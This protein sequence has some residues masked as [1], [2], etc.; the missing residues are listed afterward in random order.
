VTLNGYDF[1]LA[2]G[3]GIY[4]EPG[5]TNTVIENSNFL[6]GANRN[7]PL[8]TGVGAGDLTVRNDTFNGGGGQ[9]D[10]V[11]ALIDYK[12]PGTF[13]AQFNDF[14]NAPSDAID[15]GFGPMTTIVKYNVFDNLGTAPGTHP[16]AV[17]YFK[18]SA[19][20]SVIAFN[21]I[22]QP[23]PKGGMQGVQL[24]AAGGST[25][26]NTVIENN[27]IVAKGPSIEMSYSIAVIQD[28]GNTL[29]GAVVA[30]NYID[31]R[32]AFGPTY[33]P[34]GSNLTYFGNVNMVTG[35]QIPTPN[36]A[37]SSNVLG[38]TATPANGIAVLGSTITLTLRL[39][40][41]AVVTGTPALVLNTGGRATF[42]G[43]SGTDTLVFRYHV[44]AS[45][46]AV[47]GLAII[48]LD[49]PAGGGVRDLAGNSVN[50]T[51]FSPGF[52]G[53]SVGGR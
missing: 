11:W 6:V 24:D 15:F 16:D 23:N 22:Y 26:T 4:I 43:G 10:V 53:L 34:S 25:L 49:L 41:A 39:N 38:V 7:V 19:S 12:G 30:H 27:V 13:V 8:Y 28:P 32:G 9:T 31:H 33:P 35:S 5:A 2:G 50:L 42:T 52:P 29:D 21:T 14:L 37:S 3:W 36:G 1:G 20:N 40:V 46:K 45:D 51:A 17:Q 18:V 44:G 47:A 48:R